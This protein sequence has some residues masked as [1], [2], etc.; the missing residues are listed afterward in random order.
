MAPECFVNSKDYKV[1]GRIDVWATGIILFCMLHG[2]LPFKGNSNYETIE[3]IKAG[4]YRISPEIEKGLSQGC[5]D[6]LRM[7]LDVNPKKR[8]TMEELANHPWVDK[9]LFA[10]Q[11]EEKKEIV[12]IEPIKEE[13][14][15]DNK[16][17]PKTSAKNSPLKTNAKLVKR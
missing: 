1:D 12:H 9:N 13:I 4:K 10:Q 3:L 17:K 6:V 11:H 7:C 2:S 16:N 8:A 5:I 14:L 15:K